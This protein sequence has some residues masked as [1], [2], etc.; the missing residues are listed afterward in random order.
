[1]A[2]E[3]D[4]HTIYEPDALVRCGTPLPPDAIKLNDPVIVVE[5]LSPSTSARDPGAK[6]GTI[7]GCLRCATT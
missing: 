6:L 7:S 3:I 5:V 4:E 1:M 2:V